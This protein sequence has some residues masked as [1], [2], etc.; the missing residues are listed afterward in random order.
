MIIFIIAGLVNKNETVQ[1]INA[2]NAAI[3]NPATSTIQLEA[4][5]IVRTTPTTKSYDTSITRPPTFAASDI[6]PITE[7]TSHWSTI[8][9]IERPPD[10]CGETNGKN[11]YSALLSAVR[12][13]SSTQDLSSSDYCQNY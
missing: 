6:V 12:E 9:T 1:N 11:K 4:E 7:A 10:L 8:P 5:T 3:P 2:E 13:A